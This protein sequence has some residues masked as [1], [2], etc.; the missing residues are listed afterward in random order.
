L[1]SDEYDTDAALVEFRRAE[2]IPAALARD[3]RKI[4]GQEISVSMLWRSTLFITNIPR[5]TDDP[6]LRKL[7]SPVSNGVD[8]N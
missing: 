7:L 6:E 3:R 2:S 8:H 4:D 5:G 1:S